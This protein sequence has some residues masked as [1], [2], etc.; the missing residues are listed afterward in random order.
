MVWIIL[1]ASYCSRR[2]C[3]QP[4]LVNLIYNFSGSTYKPLPPR[5]FPNNVLESDHSIILS[6]CCR[7]KHNNSTDSFAILYKHAVS[8]SNGHYGSNTLSAFDRSNYFT[9]PISNT[10]FPISNE[11][12]DA[13]TLFSSERKFTII[14]SSQSLTQNWISLGDLIEMYI[15]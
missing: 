11:L 12:I 7:L 3:D 1:A 2:L 4:W 14:L 9:R 6:I 10:V 13:Q 8:L 5:T 15:Y